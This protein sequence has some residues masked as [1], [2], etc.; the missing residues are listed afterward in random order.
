MKLKELLEKGFGNDRNLNCAEKILYG[1]NWAYNLQLPPEALKLSAGLGG[2]LGIE[3]ICGALTGAILVISHLYVQQ[4][5][6]ES[7]RVKILEKEFITAFQKELG[8]TDCHS[9]KAKYRNPQDGCN[10][11]IFVAGDILDKIVAKEG[12]PTKK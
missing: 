3:S 8:A 5:A 1:A 4:Y 2:G 12:I 7:D 6:H 11:I 10:R 9:L